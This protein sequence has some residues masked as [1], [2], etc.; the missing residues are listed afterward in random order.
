MLED[1]SLG[2][3]EYLKFLNLVYNSPKVGPVLASQWPGKAVTGS[4]S[5]RSPDEEPD[6][7][8]L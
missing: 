2:R 8:R 4:G 1:S 6:L 7:E 5:D 3:M